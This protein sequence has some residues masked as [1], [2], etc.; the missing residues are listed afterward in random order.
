M[1]RPSCM[2]AGD[3]ILQRIFLLW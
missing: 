1:K 3:W 2:K